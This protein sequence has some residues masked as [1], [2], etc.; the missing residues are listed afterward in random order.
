M[1]KTG[2]SVLLA[3]AVAAAAW[4]QV[5][6]GS[7]RWEVPLPPKRREAYRAAKTWYQPPSQR[8]DSWPR[9]MVSLENPAGHREEAVL[10]RYSISARLV[11]IGVGGE[12]A[13]AVPFI[14]EDKRVPK[15]SPRSTHHEPL[16]LNRV[17][18]A[19]YFKRLHRAGFWPD[20]IRIQV[21]VE[22]RPGDV[23]QGRVIEA[24]LPVVWSPQPAGGGGK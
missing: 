18:M 24:E 7:V 6:I 8:L 23:D 11:R 17:V 2:F 22:P 3:S 4:A 9:A 12:G 10:I 21:M 1:R 13:W 16:Y 5:G 15:V 20:A 19:S 14:V